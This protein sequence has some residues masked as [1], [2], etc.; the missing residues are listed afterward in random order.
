M[1][2]PFRTLLCATFLT[3]LA[4]CAEAPAPSAVP[5][6]AA[7]PDRPLGDGGVSPFY[8]PPTNVPSSAGK[9]IRTEAIDGLHLPDHADHAERFLYTSVSGVGK[10]EPVVVSGQI[11]FPQGTPP[12]GGWPIVSWEHGTTGIADVCAPSWRGYFSRDRAY[13][14]RWLSAGFAVVASDYQGLGTPGP[15]PYLMYRPEGYSVLNALRATLAHYPDR[16]RNQIVLVGQSQGGGAALGSAWLAPRYA[17]DLRVIGVVATGVVTQFGLPAHPRH[18]PLPRSNTESPHMAAAFEI[19]TTEGSRKSLRPDQDVDRFMT[20]KGHDLS[21]QARQACLGDLFR[22]TDSHDVTVENSFTGRSADVE[23]EYEQAFTIPDAHLAMPVFVGTGLAD[24]EA[25]VS[26]QYNA[27]AAMCDAGTHVTWY[28]YH[29]LTHNGAVNPSA[30][31][32]LPFV[33]ALLKGKVAG[34]SCRT[35]TPVGH[36]EAAAPGIHWNN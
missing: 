14:D 27:V 24:G 10:A 34:S 7:V 11:L 8:Q 23:A 22:Y 30:N 36:E 19:L 5:A 16:L 15:H 13:L 18:A 1:S 9:M 31:D 6:P 35:L 21:R 2:L 32:S 4:A 26:Q 12:K 25:G 29:G 20:E 33:E 3:A 17:P 28:R